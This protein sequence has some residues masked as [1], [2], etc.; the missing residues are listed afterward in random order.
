MSTQYRKR[1]EF[2]EIDLD[3]LKQLIKTC[4]QMT[5]TAKISNKKIK[6]EGGY[7]IMFDTN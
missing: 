7:Y 5:L 4:D 2:Y 3:V 1:K 6:Q